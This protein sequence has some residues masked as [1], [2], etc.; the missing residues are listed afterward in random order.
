[1]PDP[2]ITDKAV[3]AAVDLSP[4][5]EAAASAMWRR[6]HRPRPWLGDEAPQYSVA[7][8]RPATERARHGYRVA[9]QVALEAAL[10]HLA[11]QLVTSDDSHVHPGEQPAPRWTS[12]GWW[13]G[14]GPEP[15]EGRPSRRNRCGGPALCATCTTEATDQP[16]TTVNQDDVVARLRRRL[17][18]TERSLS[19][20]EK[21]NDRILHALG[22]PEH[23]LDPEP[24]DVLAGIARLRQ[25]ADRDTETAAQAVA[26]DLD[27]RADDLENQARVF[28][29]PHPSTP[30]A[31]VVTTLL[32]LA[33][34]FRSDA[35][36]LRGGE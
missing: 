21:M 2:T 3:T 33:R 34:E 15:F 22:W 19:A 36:S 29:T 14:D 13:T 4:A 24:S 28:G 18:V 10:P 35:A 31:G 11:D 12:H 1:V 8:D 32:D 5:I 6:D 9:A 23:V 16:A 26:A 30:G 7:P 20:M 17:E 25:Y 27:R